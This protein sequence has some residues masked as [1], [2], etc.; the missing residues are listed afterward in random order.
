MQRKQCGTA[1]PLTIGYTHPMNLILL[2]TPPL[3]A[4][5]PVL[6]SD[7]AAFCR[8]LTLGLENQFDFE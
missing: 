3:A 5:K 8:I 6:I 7:L 4:S 2:I 1:L